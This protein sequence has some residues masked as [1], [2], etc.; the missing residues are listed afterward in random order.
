MVDYSKFSELYK[1]SPDKRVDLLVKQGVLTPEDAKLLLKEGSL[2]I[3][4]A[5][6]M[7][8]SVVGTHALPLGIATNFKINGKDYL[9][10]MV[11]E[12]PS[13]VAAASNAAKMALP[14]GFTTSADEPIMTGQVQL[15]GVKD[16]A[17]AIFAINA[18]AKQLIEKANATNAMLVQL[19]GGA[20]N[21]LAHKLTSDMLVVNFDVDVRDAMGANTINTMAEVIAPELEKLSGGKVRLRILT[22]LADKR[23]ARASV[24]YDKKVIGEDAVNGVVDAY[25]FA[26]HDVYRAC[27]HNKGIMNGID[28]VVVAT[29]NDWRAVEAGAHA[30]A[31]TRNGGYKPLTK[32]EKTKEGNLLGSIELPLALGLVGGATKT[33]PIAQISLKILGVKTAQELAQVVAAVGLAQ[34]FAALRAL[35]TEGI[36]RGH[37]KLHSKNIAVI[38]GANGSE[39]DA[40]AKQIVADKKVNVDYSR[41]VLEKLRGE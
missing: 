4:T 37:M 34:N 40:V 1:L 10:P 14:G 8:E 28:P 24:I 39:I 32:W 30:Y 5:N 20:R 41:E 26:F 12:E 29:G 27:T 38:A 36:Q 7:I 19:G 3:D 25:L 33:H 11:V 18:V 9:V 15:V 13:V 6:R 31:A 23:L 17:K 35:S 16:A 21:L 2:G 22:N